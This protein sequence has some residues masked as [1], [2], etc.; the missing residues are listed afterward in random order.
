MHI[1]VL[2]AFDSVALTVAVNRQPVNRP[3]PFAP[4]PAGVKIKKR[5]VVQRQAFPQFWHIAQGVRQ[6]VDSL[7]DARIQYIFLLRC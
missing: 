3:N 4:L 5:L 1:L 7:L 6:L 2:L